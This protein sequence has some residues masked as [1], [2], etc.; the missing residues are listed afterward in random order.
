MSSPAAAATGSLGPQHKL[1]ESGGGMRGAVRVLRCQRMPLT[2]TSLRPRL[3]DVA[4]AARPSVNPRNPSTTRDAACR[5]APMS[6]PLLSSAAPAVR[7][8]SR[9]SRQSRQ[10]RVGALAAL[11]LSPRLGRARSAQ[12]EP[13]QQPS[14]PN[15]DA[16]YRQA[17]PAVSNAVRSPRNAFVVCCPLASP[18]LPTLSAG[19]ACVS[20]RWGR[21]SARKAIFS[22]CNCNAKGKKSICT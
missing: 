13:H 11:A 16:P 18:V 1:H 3:F 8:Q 10:L 12:P 19:S 4:T 15:L 17:R 9:K 20:G 21:R 7:C 5:T 22:W 14:P 2:S 6:C